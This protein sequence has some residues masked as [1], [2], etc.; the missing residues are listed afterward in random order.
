MVD[1]DKQRNGVR[2][3]LTA[4]RKLLRSDSKVVLD[5]GCG[6]QARLPKEEAARYLKEGPDQRFPLA[7]SSYVATDTQGCLRSG[8]A[9]SRDGSCKE[10]LEAVDWSACRQGRNARRCGP[11]HAESDAVSDRQT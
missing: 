7:V 2:Q 4:C 10:G 5:I 9:G 1:L 8:T 6:V 11:G 3:A